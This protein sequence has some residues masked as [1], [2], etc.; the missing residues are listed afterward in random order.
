MRDVQIR[1]NPLWLRE[2][3]TIENLIIGLRAIDAPTAL[4][5]WHAAL[6]EGVLR[7]QRR[8]AEHLGQI[9][10]LRAVLRSRDDHRRRR[11]ASELLSAVVYER[12]TVRGLLTVLRTLADAAVWRLLDYNRAVLAVLGEGRAVRHLAS[13]AGFA[14]ELADLERLWHD[15]STVAMLTDLTTCVR[16][17]DL[18]CIES[19]TPRRWRLLEC[20]AGDG[21][22]GRRSR[23]AARLERLQTLLNTSVRPAS[24]GEPELIITECPVNRRTHHRAIEAL[25]DAAR[26]DGY[27]AAWLEDGLL[28]EVIDHRDVRAGAR[29]AMA[30]ANER[31]LAQAGVSEAEVIRYSTHV[32]RIRDRRD[33]FS[34]QVPL[35]LLPYAAHTTADICMGALNVVMTLDC[36][37]VERR[38]AR[39]GID[40]E[41]A[42]GLQA[43]ARFIRCERGGSQVDV[44]APAREQVLI[45]GLTIDSLIDLVAWM[46]DHA[47]APGARRNTALRFDERALWEA[48]PA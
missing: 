34:T 48:T 19:W 25:L 40:A 24:E 47:P 12:D 21:R 31:A 39:R 1:E 8:A 32:R 38:F 17:A 10:E 28:G 9:A 41:V 14:N 36:R 22:G 35:A 11:P 6:L 3:A 29:F 13:G 46:L 42:Q 33:T 23:Q 18:L 7:G 26:R 5:E 45:E 30:Q 15:E 27:A 20:K 16:H 2:R 43:G 4:R 44:P 37:A